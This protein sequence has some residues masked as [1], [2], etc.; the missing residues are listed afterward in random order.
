MHPRLSVPFTIK[1][2]GDVGVARGFAIFGLFSKEAG[3]HKYVLAPV[4]F[5][6]LRSLLQSRSL[7]LVAFTGGSGL[8]VT[9]VFNIAEALQVVSIMLTE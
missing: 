7:D 1:R 9:V 8:T 2:V 4:T 3:D 6:W 5:N